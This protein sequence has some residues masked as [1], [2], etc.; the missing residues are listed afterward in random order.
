MKLLIELD[1]LWV[2]GFEFGLVK[3]VAGGSAEAVGAAT[4]VGGVVV[5]VFELGEADSTPE[6]RM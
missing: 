5:V 3:V 2:D 6:I 1:D 4:R